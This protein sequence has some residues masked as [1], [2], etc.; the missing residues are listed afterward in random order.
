MMGQELGKGKIENNSVFVGSLKAG[1]YLIEVSNGA[2][3]TT[4]RFVKE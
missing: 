3:T 4:K 2:S 1:A